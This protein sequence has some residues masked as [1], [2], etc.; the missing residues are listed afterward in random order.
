MP[1]ILHFTLSSLP[2]GY[3]IVDDNKLTIGFLSNEE[4]RDEFAIALLEYVYP[5]LEEPGLVKETHT[6]NI[7]HK[8][9][10]FD[11]DHDIP[12]F[13]LQLE[14]DTQIDFITVWLF[15]ANIPTDILEEFMDVDTLPLMIN[16]SIEYFCPAL[17]NDIKE[18]DNLEL[19][20]H[21][22]IKQ[23]QEEIVPNTTPTTSSSWWP[24]S[25]FFS[26]YQTNVPPSTSSNNADIS[27]TEQSIQPNKI[28]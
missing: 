3:I 19:D 26:F 4:Q 20:E 6:N 17:E 10:T 24:F 28:L 14:F 22:D 5:Y 15:L 27:L 13:Q 12:V 2:S 16:K 7:R 11:Y 1:L 8:N 25:S 18:E 21:N 23:T 9:V